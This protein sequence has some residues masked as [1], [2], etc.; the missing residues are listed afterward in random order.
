MC[1]EAVPVGRKNT[2]AD[3][4]YESPQKEAAM[5]CHRLHREPVALLRCVRVLDGDQ[6]VRE[7]LQPTAFL[8]ENA[9]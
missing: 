7:L 3:W 2:P 5:P 4:L 8:V 1:K 6:T 9:A